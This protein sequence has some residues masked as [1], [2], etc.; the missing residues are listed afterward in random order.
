MVSM[1]PKAAP[2]WSASHSKRKICT[3]NRSSSVAKYI[4]ILLRNIVG[5]RQYTKTSQSTFRFANA[6]K[7]KAK[8]YWLISPVWNCRAASTTNLSKLSCSR[9]TKTTSFHISDRWISCTT[10]SIFLILIVAYSAAFPFFYGG[11]RYGTSGYGLMN[12]VYP[13]TGFGKS[14]S[15]RGYGLGNYGLGIYGP[16]GYG[17]GGNG[18]GL[19]ISN[20]SLGSNFGLG[21]MGSQ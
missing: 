15:Y 14:R 12:S 16:W 9:F 2:E 7:Y 3:I 8:R 11:S 21:G 19:G 4:V 1:C 17:L 10:A 5:W 20:Y 13:G 18:L 6:H